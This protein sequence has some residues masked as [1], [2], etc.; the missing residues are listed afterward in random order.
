MKIRKSILS[1]TIGSAFY[2]CGHF[3]RASFLL[4][5]ISRTQ[6]GAPSKARNR[7]ELANGAQLE[8]VG[9][10]KAYPPGYEYQ[11]I[12]IIT[13]SRTTNGVRKI[14]NNA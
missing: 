1:K 2:N 12:Y 13:Q 3:T 7:V 14:R 9:Q 10:T 8:D 5:D 4:L 6:G 11:K